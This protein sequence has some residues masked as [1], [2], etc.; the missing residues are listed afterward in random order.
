[1]LSEHFEAHIVKWNNFVFEYVD[2]IL[3]ENHDVEI[4][5]NF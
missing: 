2:M 1:M 5:I 4:R 3:D